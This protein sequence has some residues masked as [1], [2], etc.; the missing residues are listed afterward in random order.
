MGKS[1]K[2]S[3]YYVSYGVIQKR[4]CNIFLLQSGIPVGLD[5]V[6]KSDDRYPVNFVCL[7]MI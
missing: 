4:G 6:L 5:L 1:H 7:C 3:N 2:K